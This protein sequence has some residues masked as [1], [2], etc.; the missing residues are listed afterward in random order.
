MECSVTH[1]KGQQG[2]SQLTGKRQAVAATRPSHGP[3]RSHQLTSGWHWT[4]VSL[5]VCSGEA[6]VH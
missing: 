2:V 5:Q 6:E 1:T 4:N 3:I